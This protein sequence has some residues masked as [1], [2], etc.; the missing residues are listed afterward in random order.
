MGREMIPTSQFSLNV[1]GQ[2]LVR[3]EING[4]EVASAE[5]LIGDPATVR[6][7][8]RVEA[9]H[10]PVALRSRLVDAAFALPTVRSRPRVQTAVALGDVGLIEAI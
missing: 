7:R 9:G 1:Q 5:V 3:A 10:L 4:H 8:F 2:S 6:V